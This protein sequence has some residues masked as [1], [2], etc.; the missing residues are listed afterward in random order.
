MLTKEGLQF[1]LQLTDYFHG[2]WEDPEW[3]KRSFS[4]V[5]VALGTHTLASGIADASIRTA[6]QGASEKAIVN[7]AQKVMSSDPVP[8]AR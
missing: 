3:G 5:L 8:P 6:I 1:I 4:Q 7:A 2:H